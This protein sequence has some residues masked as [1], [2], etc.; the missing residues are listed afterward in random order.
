M[1][2]YAT[3]LATLRQMVTIG[4]RVNLTL[5]RQMEFDDEIM[6]RLRDLVEEIEQEGVE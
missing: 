1:L 3:T 5:D 2:E 6:G 4:E